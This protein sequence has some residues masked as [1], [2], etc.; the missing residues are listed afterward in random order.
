M[1][2]SFAKESSNVQRK[3]PRPRV[4]GIYQASL[5]L[6]LQQI[7]GRWSLPGYSLHQDNSS[8][9]RKYFMSYENLLSIRFSPTGNFISITSKG[10]CEWSF[11]VDE[12]RQIQF[13][14]ELNTAQVRFSSDRSYF[15]YYDLANR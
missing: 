14:R 2:S 8:S 9:R 3:K 6:P 10:I 1:G 5:L 12:L 4:W 15:I 11:T 7:S 13:P